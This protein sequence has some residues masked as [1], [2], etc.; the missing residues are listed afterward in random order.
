MKKTFR[1][2]AAAALIIA[3]ST[4]SWAACVDSV[5]AVEPAI[6]NLPDAHQKEQAQRATTLAWERVTQYG[7]EA[8]CERYL[9]QAKRIAKIK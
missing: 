3:V 9:G 5:K 7:D 2:V 4:P 1:F 8:G 6:S